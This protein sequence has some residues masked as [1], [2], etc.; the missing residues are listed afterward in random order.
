MPTSSPPSPRRRLPWLV[1]AGVGLLAVVWSFAVPPLSVVDEEAHAL[2]AVALAHG[3][4]RGT[5]RVFTVEEIGLNRTVTT[6]RVPR[7]YADAFANA[8]CHVFRSEQPASCS[9]PIPTTSGLLVDAATTAGTYPPPWYLVVG[10]PSR[11]LPPSTGLPAMRVVA[12]LL[13]AAALGS[14]A[15]S[16]SRLGRSGS[17]WRWGGLVLATTPQVLHLAGGI[18]PNGAEIAVAVMTW[19]A[20]VELA[21]RV[22]TRAGVARL[23]VGAAALVTLRPVSVVWLAVVVVAVLLT[24]PWSRVRELARDPRVRVAVGVVAA[25]VVATLAWLVW[26]D[27]LSAF[28]GRPD[29]QGGLAGTAARSWEL[30]TTRLEQMVGRPGYLDVVLPAWVRWTWFLA[31]PALLVLAWLRVPVRVRLVL[32]ALVV[33]TAVLPVVA[34]LRLADTIGFAWQGRYTLPVAVGV[35]LLAGAH[36]DLAGVRGR[37]WAVAGVVPLL[38]AHVA[39]VLV[40]LH[41][42]EVG[43]TRGIAEVLGPGAPWEPL[44]PDLLL[45]AGAVVGASLLGLVVVLGGGREAA[46]R[47]YGRA[48]AQPRP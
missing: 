3:E 6:V 13:V 23:V 28:Q 8:E 10:L 40:T 42:Y 47:R 17:G 15:V 9:P 22:V 27:T 41:R 25:V 29:P 44:V 2:Y 21:S 5:E 12:A 37:P 14:A 30:T 35:P 31:V 34:E 18:N 1:A 33:G 32:A 39:A 4:L 43:T 19:T 26:R 16:L 20:G 24:V 48:H 11:V 38:V 7:G 46:P 36:L 45:V